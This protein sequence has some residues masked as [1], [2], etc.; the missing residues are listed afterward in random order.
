M[1]P[2]LPTATRG[3]DQSAQSTPGVD[4]IAPDLVTAKQVLL[5]RLDQL[6][7]RETELDLSSR[8]TENVVQRATLPDRPVARSTTTI[9]IVGFVGGGLLGIFVALL[10]A[11][12]SD[13]L[14]NADQVEAVLGKTLVGDVP[15][16]R[17]LT[18][19]PMS[20]LK[21]LPPGVAKS[22]DKLCVRAEAGAESGGAVT[23]LVSATDRGAGCSTLAVALANRFAVTGQHVVLIDV[24]LRRPDL[25]RAPVE[26]AMELAKLLGA[27]DDP[28]NVRRLT[29]AAAS[30]SDRS[31][32][33]A[34][35]I[36]VVT[37]RTAESVVALRRQAVQTVIDAAKRQ[38]GVVI[39][40]GGVLL[41]AASTIQLAQ[42]VDA[43][44]LA[45]PLTRQRRGSL[46][47]LVEQLDDRR[48]E[49]LPVSTHARRR[50]RSLWHRQG[51]K[52]P[53]PP[54][55]LPN[56]AAATPNGANT[57]ASVTSVS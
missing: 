51:T 11:R 8:V 53:T 57:V 28:S 35:R 18:N 16:E 45:V 54:A 19:G 30:M 25:S 24:D 40:D 17:T 44:V 41:D 36:Q 21:R 3:T 49:L 55:A 1:A 50:R 32:A 31:E 5:A 6:L 13:R 15:F 48:G 43:V 56:V 4:Q 23:V 22:V 14:I 12:L 9:A 2:Y 47:A 42:R 52:P 39:F 38:G 27:D 10:V 7:A 34:D 26:A 46:T 29:G 20:A 33:A 37:I